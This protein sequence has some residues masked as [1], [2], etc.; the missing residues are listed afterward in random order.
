MDTNVKSRK[1]IFRNADHVYTAIIS[2]DN[3]GYSIKFGGKY[4]KCINISITI[5]DGVPLYGTISHI[6]S[7]QECT[8]DTIL[9]HEETANFV[10]AC[11]QIC[12]MTFPGLTRIVFDDMSNIDCG[13]SKNSKPPRKLE[14][15]FSLAP[16]HMAV[17]GQ[18]WY[19]MKFGAKLENEE[20]Y[21]KYRDSIQILYEP[22]NI[23]YSKF[24][25]L[26]HLTPEQEAIL[27]P[28]YKSDESWNMLFKSIPRIQRCTALYNWLPTFITRILKIQ[29]TSM[30]WF[31][32]INTMEQIPIEILPSY[33]SSD[34]EEHK[35]GRRNKTHRSKRNNRR[36]F[37]NQFEG[38]KMFA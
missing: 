23:E 30:N 38:W 5:V 8:L 27:E 7:E 36:L 11:L 6:Q 4:E 25:Q 12:S 28:L 1:I 31:I 14:K 20:L 35:G 22:K 29:Y 18:T 24:K 9:L 3:Y 15:P 32:T 2:P 16:L 37:T 13:L 21:K 33:S 10:R 17:Y 26:N 19:E 34:T